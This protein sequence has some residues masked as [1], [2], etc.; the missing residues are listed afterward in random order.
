MTQ[1]YQYTCS[2]F[3]VKSKPCHLILC[4]AAEASSNHKC[5][6]Y[7]YVNNEAGSEASDDGFRRDWE[8]N[9]S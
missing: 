5:L 4:T 7:C 8:V 3:N 6:G 2:S 9:R 1:H